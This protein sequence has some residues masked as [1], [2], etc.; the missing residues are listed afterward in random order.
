MNDNQKKLGLW[1]IVLLGFNSII[2]SGIFLLPASLYRFAGDWSVAVVFITGAI[3]ATIALCFAEAAGYFSK[4]GAAYVYTKEAFGEFA[5]FEVGF[6]KWFMQCIAWAVMAVAF[7]NILSS[8]FGFADNALLC[9]LIVAGIVLLLT[10]INLLGVS[11]TKT[12]NN[13]STIAKMLP[14][15]FLIVVGVW[16]I[17]P[18]NIIPSANPNPT[19]SL[20]SETIVSALILA[21]YS[22]TGFETFG[23]AAEDMDS[24]KKNLPKAICLSLGIVMI[25]YALVMAVTVGVLGEAVATSGTPLADAARVV[26]GEFGFWLITI[27]S[28]VSIA[29]INV[30]ASFHIPRALLPLADDKMIPSIFGKKTINGVPAVAIIASGL[31]TVP[32]AL[33]GS[34]AELAM[35]SVV[36]RF[37]QYIPTCISLLIFRKRFANDKEAQQS[38]KAPLGP[39]LPVLGVII[40]L[41]LL[42]DQDPMKIVIGLGF[43]AVISPLYFF[44]KKNS[45]KQVN[46]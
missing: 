19:Y 11:A 37:A 8:T 22:F 9:N 13:I 2:G 7:K 6:L 36:A 10:G 46:A 26:S 27:G 25:F 12:V 42:S 38:F 17:T 35:L 14:L 43:M 32:I 15:V 39:V 24:P 23:T 34:F 20:N 21:F 30:A 45:Q 44:A 29:G 5:G 4:N 28:I 18:S 41:A 16:Y 1:S 40:C 3:V 31:V 33:S